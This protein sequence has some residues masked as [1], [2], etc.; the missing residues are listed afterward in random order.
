M[1]SITEKK[2][3]KIRVSGK[4]ETEQYAFASALGN[5]QKQIASEKDVL[6]RIEPVEVDLIAAKKCSY[7]ERF[8]F[9]FFPR[10]RTV[11][12]L[13]LEVSV[14]V[15]QIDLT[16]IDFSEEMIANPERLN[17]SFLTRR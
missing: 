14:Q 7:T 8:L 17:L 3:R 11:Y 13:E 5:I 16:K 1:S 10:K 12:Q 15:S 9:F 6:L 2:L 4:G